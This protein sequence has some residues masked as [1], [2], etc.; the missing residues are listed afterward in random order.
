MG[1]VF[2]SYSTKNSEYANAIRKVLTDKG[3]QTWMAPGNIPVGSTYAGEITRALKGASGLVLVLTDDAQSSEWVDREVERAINYGKPIVP[4]A[5]GELTLNDNFELYLGNKQIV[6]I[7]QLS[8]ENKDFR[9]IL[10][11][12]RFLASKPGTAAIPNMSLTGSGEPNPAEE[13]TAAG[14]MTAESRPEE[15]SPAELFREGVLYQTGREG[16]E[17][18]ET[19]AFFCYLRAAEAGHE[20]AGYYLAW[21]YKNGTGTRKDLQKAV[22]WFERSAEAGNVYAIKALA[23]C[24][25]TG[26]GVKKDPSSAYAWLKKGED[27]AVCCLGLGELYELGEGVEKDL[28][29]AL[30]YYEKAEMMGG[31]EEIAKINIARVKRELQL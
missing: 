29:E 7:H 19:E 21:L 16:Y 17:R 9:E 5:L 13:H 4:I 1:Y 26:S 22:Y 18:D 11:L 20:M 15:M 8:E 12:I 2:I 23:D 6:P 28:F 25:R 31:A 24:Y 10:D 3:I 30:Y 27:S 14:N